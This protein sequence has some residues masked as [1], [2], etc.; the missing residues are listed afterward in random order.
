GV[1]RL[2]TKLRSWRRWKRRPSACRILGL[3]AFFA[4]IG[5]PPPSQ[6][7]SRDRK[8]DRGGRLGKTPQICKLDG[9]CRGKTARAT[10]SSGPRRKAA[11]RWIVDRWLPASDL[12][13]VSE[14]E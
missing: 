13:P 5:L 7:R 1:Q 3:A 10:E 8:M 12:R 2:T 11:R 6:K 14:S 4:I 9:D